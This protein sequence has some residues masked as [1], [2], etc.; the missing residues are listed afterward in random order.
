MTIANELSNAR[1]IYAARVLEG[2]PFGG[3]YHQISDGRRDGTLGRAGQ[4]IAGEIECP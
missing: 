1:F 4:W 2:C 3:F